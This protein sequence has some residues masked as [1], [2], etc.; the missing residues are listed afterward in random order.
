MVWYSHLFN[1]SF[2][3]FVVIHSVKDFRVAHEAEVDMFLKL[4][5]FLHDSVSVGNL[6]SCSLSLQ[7]PACT[8]E[9]LVPKLLKPSLKDFE[10]NLTCMWNEHSCKVVW[11][12]LALS[13]LGTGMKT[14]NYYF[15]K[16]KWWGKGYVQQTG[17]KFH[18][19]WNMRVWFIQC[20]G[21][22]RERN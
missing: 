19:R 2:P 4:P 21:R 15:V 18:R 3:Q 17:F 22:K 6:T 20:S 7:N 16:I 5:C 11:T 12:L 14:D 1:K 10:H 13:F 8:A 9:F